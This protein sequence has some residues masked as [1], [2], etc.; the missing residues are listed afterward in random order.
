VADQNGEHITPEEQKKK[1]LGLVDLIRK[2]SPEAIKPKA[3][4]ILKRLMQYQNELDRINQELLDNHPMA[5]SEEEL[6]EKRDVI[7]K[8]LIDHASVN[9]LIVSALKEVMELVNVQP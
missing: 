9:N 2:N 6:S 4:V 7:D 3:E 1:L 8:L 5:H